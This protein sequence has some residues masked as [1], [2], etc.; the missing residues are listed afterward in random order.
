MSALTKREEVFVDTIQQWMSEGENT[1]VYL[2]G[3][4]RGP[5]QLDERAQSFE[6]REDQALS[7]E[8]IVAL[9]DVG[10]K[11]LRV[12]AEQ[13]LDLLNEMAT[14]DFDLALR[15]AVN[16]RMDD[17]DDESPSFMPGMH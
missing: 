5:I 4:S 13:T 11:D 10:V 17:Q 1:E 9:K 2:A 15:E 14:R 6:I 8:L 12:G 16:E 3:S 7:E